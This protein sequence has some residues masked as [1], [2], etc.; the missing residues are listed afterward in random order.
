M[1]I[2]TIALGLVIIG[3]IFIIIEL[4]MPGFGVFGII[5]GIATIVGLVIGLLFVPY[6]WV[7]FV[8]VLI[9][10]F[11]MIKYFKFPKNLILEDKV[12]DDVQLD[13]SFLVG[14]EGVTLTV[15]K[16]VGKCSIDDV[17][18]ECYSSCG[19]IQNDVS[20][21]VKEI[22]ENKIFVKPKDEKTKDEKVILQK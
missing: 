9:S 4:F 6:F 16:P 7:V 10:L 20:I 12:G 18:Y 15:L 22:K 13:K 1:N 21:I 11:V 8:L 2:D 17:D 14:K 19:M 3:Y 5:G